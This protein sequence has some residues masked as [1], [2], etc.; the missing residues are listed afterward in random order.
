MSRLSLIAVVASLAGVLAP[1]AGAK[2]VPIRHPGES[3]DHGR[4]RATWTAW[5]VRGVQV[6][7]RL[8]AVT[9]SAFTS[10]WTEGHSFDARI[11][12]KCRYPTA[13]KIVTP[14]KRGKR[15]LLASIAA[16]APVS[17]RVPGVSARCLAPSKY[18]GF[19]F[20][21]LIIKPYFHPQYMARF[22]GNGQ[23]VPS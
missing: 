9:V 5:K 13:K 18:V 4:A 15:V 10:E 11:G 3:V 22:A 2:T 8:S 23:L 1:A 14:G 6:G 17:L 19:Y 21:G 7:V 12:L 16:G 20:L